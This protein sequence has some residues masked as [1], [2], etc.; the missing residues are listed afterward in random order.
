MLRALSCTRLVLRYTR[1]SHTIQPFLTRVHTN[2]TRQFSTQQPDNDSDPARVLVEQG[3]L[4]GAI[5]HILS[6]IDEMED[7]TPYPK[8]DI[9][10]LYCNLGFVNS[11]QGDVQ[12]AIENWQKS[13]SLYDKDPIVY[14]NLGMLFHRNGRLETAEKMY[15]KALELDDSLVP[16]THRLATV[17]RQQL[18]IKKATKDALK[19]QEQQDAQE[20]HFQDL[21]QLLKRCT[22]LDPYYVAAGHDYALELFKSNDDDRKLAEQIADNLIQLEKVL[23]KDK[24][25]IEGYPPRRGHFIKAYILSKTERIDEAISMYEKV[26][27]EE[28]D[29]DF[30][31]N[32]LVN[33]API[34]ELGERYDLAKD[35][36]DKALEYNP[37]NLDLSLGLTRVMFKMGEFQEAEELLRALVD[38]HPLNDKVYVSLATLLINNNR[39]I[40][41][42]ELVTGALETYPELRNTSL[43]GYAE[44]MKQEGHKQ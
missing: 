16:V 2:L 11:L 13:I 38:E 21:L 33:L 29:Y 4:D 18:E 27:L 32:T 42:L 41:A 37:T 23:Y 9:A 17:W 6:S 30:V 19:T 25:Q 31:G 8:R 15:K 40:E 24:N 12:K 5:K 1:V 44:L 28:N 3:N 22:E 7:L 20:K 34:Y 35:A 14:D 26:L 36:Y 43:A 39:D 10:A